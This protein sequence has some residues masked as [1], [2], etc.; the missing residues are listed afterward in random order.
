[1]TIEKLSLKNITVFEELDIAFSQGINILIGEN[2]TGKTHVMKILYAISQDRKDL[3][4]M[5]KFD[6]KYN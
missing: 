6:N 1:M 5:Y 3:L 2:G 4:E